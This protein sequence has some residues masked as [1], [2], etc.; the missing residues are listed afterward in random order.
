MR[1]KNLELN[2]ALAFDKL[3]E[4]CQRAGAC[5]GSEALATKHGKSP[6]TLHT[7]RHVCQSV[8]TAKQL[9]VSDES[10]ELRS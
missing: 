8:M 2:Q 7:L 5:C 10:A 3:E 1:S 6:L 4:S 9:D